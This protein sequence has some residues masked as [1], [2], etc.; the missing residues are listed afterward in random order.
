MKVTGLEADMADTMVAAKAV[1]V[2]AE[3]AVVVAGKE[4]A[5]PENLR[6]PEVANI[7][8]LMATVRTRVPS[9]TLRMIRTIRVLLLQTC[10]VEVRLLA[11]DGVGR[12]GAVLNSVLSGKLVVYSEQSITALLVFANMMCA[13][14]LLVSVL[15]MLPYKDDPF[16][17]KC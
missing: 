14:V 1:D 10:R 12:E 2:D 3:E 5:T 4:D 6:L 16:L 9:V 8:S 15:K 7:A 13:N 11:F 17:S